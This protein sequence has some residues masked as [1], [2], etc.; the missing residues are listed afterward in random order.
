MSLDH[1][2]ASL[3]F[4]C[5][6]LHTCGFNGLG[7]QQQCGFERM[8]KGYATCLGRRLLACTVQY[9]R[10]IKTSFFRLYHVDTIRHDGHAS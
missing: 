4:F 7:V 6:T 1:G 2:W 3:E 8:E 10:R 5:V 9:S